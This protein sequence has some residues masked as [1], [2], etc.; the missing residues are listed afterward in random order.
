MRDA[1]SEND[2]GMASRYLIRPISDSDGPPSIPVLE[3]PDTRNFT[4]YS[5]SAHR[6]STLCQPSTSWTSSS[7][8]QSLPPMP[9]GG[10][11]TTSCTYHSRARP[12]CS[13]PTVK[14]GSS[15][16]AYITL[17]GSHPSPVSRT[18]SCLSMVV[19]PICLGP[20][21]ACMRRSPRP[22]IMPSRSLRTYAGAPDRGTAP[23]ACPHHGFWRLRITPS[24]SSLNASSATL[25]ASLQEYITC[26]DNA[27]KTDYF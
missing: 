7:M 9:S 8:M 18:A 23:P 12:M 3:E 19:L 17:R 26:A 21:T 13:R 4:S 20:T 24:L 10:S 27:A 25:R 5:R 15:S 22:S 6:L 16:E 2:S 11:L 14:G 1:Y